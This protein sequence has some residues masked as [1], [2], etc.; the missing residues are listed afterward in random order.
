[1]NLH[2]Y[3]SKMLFKKYGLPVPV[4]YLCNSVDEIIEKLAELTNQENQMKWVAKC[5]VHAGGRGK[6]GGVICTE[7]FD[8][9]KRFAEYW[10]GQRLVTYQTDEKGQPVNKILLEQASSIK[11][12][13]YLGAV[14]DRALKRV[15]IIAST[16]G[17]MD[18]ESTATNTPEL[19]FTMP[20]DPLLGPCAYQGRELAFKLGLRGKLVNQFAKIFTNLAKLFIENDLS[21][22]EVNPLVITEDE[23]LLCV[24]AKIVLDDNALYRHPELS[25]LRDITQEDERESIATKQGLSYVSLS[26]N[27][28]CMVNGAGLAMATMDIIKLYGGEPANFLDVGGGTTK[29]RVCE[30]FKLIVSDSHVKAILVNIFGGIVRCDLI[31][32]GIIA[33]IEEIDLAIP[34]VVR[35]E[36]NNAEI[37]RAMLANSDLNIISAESLADAAQK[38]SALAN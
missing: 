23:E 19:I 26:G 12:E 5:Q 25:Q 15:V 18:I 1:M 13:L 3:Q 34:V 33:A 21:L 36:G 31:A 4:N 20:I 8:E 17:G 22:A 11:T 37:A 24:D 27:I 6:A 29:E 10:L 14:V 7:N 2:E 16:E 28:G 38:I 9:I 32:E 30:A 35:L